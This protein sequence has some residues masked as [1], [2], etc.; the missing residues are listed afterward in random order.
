[1]A[2]QLSWLEHLV[3]TQGVTGSN[4]VTATTFLIAKNRPVGQE[5]K[6]PPFHGG[7]MG[8]IPVRVTTT[9]SRKQRSIAV[10]ETLFFPKISSTTYLPLILKITAFDY[11]LAVFYVPRKACAL[12][13]FLCPENLSELFFFLLVLIF[14]GALCAVLGVLFFFHF[15]LV[16]E[17]QS[18][19]YR[20]A[21]ACSRLLEHM[22]I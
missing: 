18:V 14:V 19:A 5:V 6:T 11:L 22:G 16:R 9:K 12:R 3:H 15:N 2:V 7:I 17:A 1:M 21:V 8:S 4:P 10:S 13:V 20:I